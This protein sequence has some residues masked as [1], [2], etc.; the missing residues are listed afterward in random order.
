M[1]MKDL[2]KTKEVKVN[3]NDKGPRQN[4]ILYFLSRSPKRY[5]VVLLSNNH[6][7]LK[8]LDK[9][10][11]S[12]LQPEVILFRPYSAGEILDILKDRAETGLNR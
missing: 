6:R 8:Q 12:S 1:C 10:T 4:D 7:Y 11:R 9:S 3:W 2:I 5:S